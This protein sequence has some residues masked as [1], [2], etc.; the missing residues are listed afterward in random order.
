MSSGGVE[1]RAPGQHLLTCARS[2]STQSS[3]IDRRLHG[4]PITSSWGNSE[5]PEWFAQPDGILFVNS[6]ASARHFFAHV[7]AESGARRIVRESL[8]PLAPPPRPPR[9]ESDAQRLM[10]RA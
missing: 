8:L 7:S 5:F 10:L 6:N 3:I 4:P 1:N 9:F 2:R